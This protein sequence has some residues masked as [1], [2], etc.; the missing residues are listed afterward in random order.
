ALFKFDLAVVASPMDAKYFYR[1]NVTYEVVTRALNFA[2]K[3]FDSVP[4][5][6]LASFMIVKVHDL[7]LEQRLYHQ[8]MLMHYLENAGAKEIGLTD[9]EIDRVY[10]SVFEARIQAINFQESK[11]AAANWDKY[12]A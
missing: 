11:R 12:G 4:L 2:K 3:K 10:S 5:L 6:N 8:Y 7:V 1:R 9:K